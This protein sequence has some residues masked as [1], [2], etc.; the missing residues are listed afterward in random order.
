MD[1]MWRFDKSQNSRQNSYISNL[2]IFRTTSAFIKPI[3]KKQNIIIKSM[4]LI[5][6]F[7]NVVLYIIFHE[8]L[9][10]F[11]EGFL[12]TLKILIYI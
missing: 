9:L 10:L 1:T 3:A 7:S 4:V 6:K 11:V 5:S 8:I 12:E 2:Q